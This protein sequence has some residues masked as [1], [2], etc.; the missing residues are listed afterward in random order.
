MIAY[1]IC[2]WLNSLS[3]IISRSFMLLKNGLFHS[4]LW[5]SNIPLYM[6][7]PSF[8]SVP[9]SVDIW[10][11]SLSWLLKMVLQWILE[12]IH[13][14]ELCFSLDICPGV[15]LLDHI[16]VLFLVFWG[17]SVLFSIVVIPIYIPTRNIGGFLLLHTLFSIYY[18]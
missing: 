6:Y 7:I 15:R 11:V 4:F 13:L 8:L 5:L 14:F 12:C 2:L 3:M 18:L 9:L 17:T 16:V 10:V 1:D